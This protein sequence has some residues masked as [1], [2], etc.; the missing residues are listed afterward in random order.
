MVKIDKKLEN[1]S[2]KYQAEWME[3]KDLKVLAFDH[4]QIISE[5][6]TYIR[7]YVEAN[8]AVL[9]DLLPRKFTASELRVL[10]ELVYDKTFDVRNFHYRNAR[11]VFLTG[12]HAI[13]SLTGKFIINFTLQQSLLVSNYLNI[14]I[15]YN[16]VFIRI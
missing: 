8:P 16:Y 14:L 5:A 4:N 9:F 6:I 1:L 2:D 7:Q 11:L 10:Y 3:I 15:L 12:R 13:I